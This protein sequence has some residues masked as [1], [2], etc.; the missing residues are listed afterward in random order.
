MWPNKVL[1]FYKAKHIPTMSILV[2]LS[3]NF[4][5]YPKLF[6]ITILC[7]E[8]SE[9]ESGCFGAFKMCEKTRTRPLSGAQRVFTFWKVYFESL[10]LRIKMSQGFPLQ[11][12]SPS[13][14][15][16]CWWHTAA[17]ACPPPPELLIM[18]APVSLIRPGGS[19]PQPPG[20]RAS[21]PLTFALFCASQKETWLH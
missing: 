1:N 9:R 6:K 5:F 21:P 10:H 12:R 4:V 18:G 20:L 3:L 15:K 13:F 7:C 16:L 8:V 19:P 17:L 14:G 2:H 11:A